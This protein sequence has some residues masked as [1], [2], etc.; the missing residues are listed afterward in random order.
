MTWNPSI[1]AWTERGQTFVRVWAPEARSVEWA[2][3][4]TRGAARRMPLDQDG[5]GYFRG[6][7]SEVQVGDRYRFA[8]D[9]QGPFPDPASR[10][11]PTGVHGPSQVVDPKSFSWTDGA[12]RGIALADLILYELHIGT[13]TPQ[14]TFTAAA[15]QLPRLRDLGVTAIEV[16]PVADFPGA[17]NWGYDGVALFAPARCYGTPDDLRSFINEAHRL[18]LAVHL[19]VV[20]NHL[21]PDG[22]YHGAYSPYYVSK[23]HHSPWGA[24][25]NFD[26][27][28]SRPVRDFFVENA[29]HWIH[30]Y[31]IDGLRL[32]ATHAIV[33]DGPRHFL[34]ELSGRVRES[35]RGVSRQVLL[36]AEDVRNLACMVQPEAESGW[37]LDAVWSDDFHHQMR[38]FLAGDSDG[39]FADFC[40]TTPEIAV[41]ASKGWYYCGQHAPYFAAPRGTDPAGIAPVRF[42]FFLQNHDQ[43]GNRAFGDRLH[44]AIDLAA[45]RAATMLWLMLPET[46]LLFMGQEWAASSPFQYFT[47]HNPEL[48]RLVTEG[49][50]NEFSRFAMFSDAKSRQSIPDP[51]DPATFER[52]KLNWNELPDAPQAATLRYYTA[53]LD[54]R[55]SEA[56][57]RPPAGRFEIAALDDITLLLRQ[58]SDRQNDLLILIRMRGAGSTDLSGAPLAAAGN[59]RGWSVLLT[60]EEPAFATDAAPPRIDPEAMRFEFARPG[61]V[62]LKSSVPIP[63]GVK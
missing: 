61:G 34:A 22:A 21:G 48:G 51:Q 58:C 52:S 56:A 40:G 13:F 26:G 5:H 37:G 50:R 62:I 27:P 44:H 43:V 18:S 60:S 9:G 54:V 46:P 49:R 25:L 1:G 24:A 59:G 17:R 2:V 53:L 7:S 8:I 38:R 16:M 14:G 57:L 23:T 41:T 6:I 55:K 20:Y 12:W 4:Q 42:T 36:I 35:L 31:H 19:D 33:D 47:D 11:Q 29:L 39:Y 3:E 10:F 15:E 30:E 32:D 63:E 28:S 45:Y